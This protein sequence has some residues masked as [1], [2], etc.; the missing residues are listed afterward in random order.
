MMSVR[1]ADRAGVAGGAWKTIPRPRLFQVHA[2]VVERQPG[3]T[4]SGDTAA[5]TMEAVAT[6]REGKRR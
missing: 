3:M 1:D 4:G 6:R 2:V 5:A